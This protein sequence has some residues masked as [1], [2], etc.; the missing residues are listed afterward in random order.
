[1]L[2][3][4]EVRDKQNYSEMLRLSKQLIDAH[5][6]TLADHQ[7]ILNR[8]LVLN[9]ELELVD[10]KQLPTALR[11][12]LVRRLQAD[13]FNSWEYGNDQTILNKTKEL[14]KAIK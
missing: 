12:Q 5:H 11:E 13:I 3:T 7:R 2:Q 9:D 6:L 4:L 1:M 14:L 10:C 8:L